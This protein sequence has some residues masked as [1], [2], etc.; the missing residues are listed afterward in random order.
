LR[1]YLEQARSGKKLGM[2]SGVF[3][4]ST[5]LPPAGDSPASDTAALLPP[6]RELKAEMAR[7]DA[8]IA[9]G[10]AAERATDVAPAGVTEAEPAAAGAA[11]EAAGKAKSASKAK[12]AGKGKGAAT[13]P[14]PPAEPAP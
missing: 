2:F 13:P 3:S 5:L 11:G 14:T 9:A 10:T 8:E 1:R 7:L 12:A 4:G 6:S